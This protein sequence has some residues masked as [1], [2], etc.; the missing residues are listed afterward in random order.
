MEG[1]P[2]ITMEGLPWITTEGLPWTALEGTI[3]VRIFSSQLPF[4]LLCS[5]SSLPSPR[6]CCCSTFPRTSPRII[7]ECANC[8]FTWTT[9][10]VLRV[11]LPQWMW[12][13]YLWWVLLDWLW[14]GTLHLP[15]QEL[16]LGWYRR[17]RRTGVQ[18][19]YRPVAALTCVGSRIFTWITSSCSNTVDYYLGLLVIILFKLRV[20][21]VRWL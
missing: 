7:H 12:C 5:T 11:T 20:H 2:W 21:F 19:N 17:E 1:L 9:S 14:P 18:R 4:L 13:L 15:A 16:R 6:T 10:G 8:G 3:L